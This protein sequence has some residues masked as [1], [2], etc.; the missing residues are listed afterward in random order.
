MDAVFLKLLNMS[1][2]ASWLILAVIPVRLLMKNAPKW[3]CCLLWLLV[4]AALVL[5]VRPESPVSVIP[6]SEPIFISL[7][8]T[9]A[10]ALGTSDVPEEPPSAAHTPTPEFNP[11][12][13]LHL[14]SGAWA[15]GMGIMLLCA[16]WSWLRLR[17]Q[18]AASVEVQPGVFLCDDISS[19]FILGCFHPRIYLPS[20]L[21]SEAAGQV[22]AHEQAHL[23]RKDHLWKP[24][25]FLL[26]TLHWFN[27][28]VWAAYIL[29]CRDIELACDEKVIRN[30]DSS[31]KKMY[32][33]ILLQCSMPRYS[34]A[35]CPLAFGEVSVKQ[36]VA[37]V[38]HYRKPT[39]RVVSAAVLICIA[40]CLGFLTKPVTPSDRA[41]SDTPIVTVSPTLPPKRHAIP[42]DSFT[43]AAEQFLNHPSFM[44]SISTADQAL[45]GS[46]QFTVTAPGLSCMTTD[47]ALRSYYD[48]EFHIQYADGS[49]TLQA[50]KDISTLLLSAEPIS[51]W[52]SPKDT[53][54]ASAQ[55]VVYL[56][57]STGTILRMDTFPARE[58]NQEPMD[59]S[60]L[61]QD[62]LYRAIVNEPKLDTAQWN[63]IQ[64]LAVTEYQDSSY[65]AIRYTQAREA[66]AALLEYTT[67]AAGTV[68]LLTFNSGDLPN[69]QG[70][71]NTGFAMNHG[72]SSTG[73]VYWSVLADTRT[74]TSADGTEAILEQTTDTDFTAIRFLWQDLTYIDAPI[75][76]P[77]F[78]T[79]LDNPVIPPRIVLP[80]SGNTLLSAL[81]MSEPVGYTTIRIN[82]P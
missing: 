53:P 67:D 21:D 25:G 24:F 74:D 34:I 22:L 57:P 56:D 23:S 11:R 79:D 60:F 39:F 31:G 12:Q 27:P 75:T 30:L 61:G 51:V 47:S 52:V 54:T 73:S 28:L 18:V 64:L 80:V 3:T 71:L 66:K 63:Q 29:L 9:D 69:T 5:P 35:A 59:S 10:T 77:L 1:V 72:F 42:I 50:P 58:Q 4:G 8:P 81:G 62:A 14:C 68:R 49:F 41:D 33:E 55:F 37:A 15:V 65:A 70:A 78:I 36:R 32:S 6:N 7:S 2:T 44:E 43:A 20:A 45:L 48:A 40:L 17:K 26:L 82:E 19:P 13:L 46:N 16:A 76:G 38:L